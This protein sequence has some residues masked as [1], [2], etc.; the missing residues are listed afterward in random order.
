MAQ[1]HAL[2][3]ITELIKRSLIVT[4]I[5][6]KLPINFMVKLSRMLWKRRKGLRQ[7]IRRQCESRYLI[8]GSMSGTMRLAMV[9]LW[10]TINDSDIWRMIS[11]TVKNV[12]IL[13][14]ASSTAQ[15]RQTLGRPCDLRG[16]IALYIPDTYGN[17]SGRLTGQTSMWEN[18]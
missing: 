6:G 16:G 5:T 17:V 9:T 7:E 10:I 8:S 1:R 4:V 14:I 12:N 13:T 18:C 3:Y 15:P 11:A 2:R